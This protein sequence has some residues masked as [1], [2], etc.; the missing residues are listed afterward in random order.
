MKVKLLIL[1]AVLCLFAVTAFAALPADLTI[2]EPGA[3]EGSG[4]SGVVTL[5]DGVQTVGDRG[6]AA[7]EV[8]ALIVPAGCTSVAGTVLADGQAAYVL[9][10]G[11]AT[12]I[13]GTLTDVPFLFAPADSVMADAAGFH[14]LDT[15]MLQDNVY[16]DLSGG[17]AQPLCVANDQTDAVTIP[18]LVDGKPVASLD[19]MAFSGCDGL[20]LR[21]PAY[22][23]VPE[24]VT[25]ERYET[26]TVTSPVT[27][28]TVQAGEYASW[29]VTAAGVYGDAS[30]T[31]LFDNN[32]TTS[33]TVTAE[34][35]VTYAP[36]AGGTLTVT[37]TVQDALGDHASAA[38]EAVEVAAAVP[39]YRALL[40]GNVYSGALNELKGTDTDVRAMR[41]MLS[42]M[43][44]SA[45][46][47]NTQI[48][49]NASAILSA[50]SSNFASAGP[51]D[52][53]LFYFAGHGTS[54]GQLVGTGSTYINPAT[55]RA[56]LDKIPGQKI[57]ILDCCYSGAFISRSGEEAS[58]S[59]F[60][61][62]IISAF[63]WMSR[64]DTD[65]DAGGYHVLTACK[66]E[67]ESLSLTADSN[68]YWG[69]FTYGLCYSSG[70]DSWMQK[71]V[72]TL[73]ADSDGNGAI[74]LGEAY[75]GTLERLDYLA[76]MIELSQ[77]TQYTGDSSFVLWYK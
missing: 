43:T 48:D 55:L 14:A 30:Y 66:K 18:K 36:T 40:V 59:A 21:V 4:L 3:L 68:H 53:S 31:W 54:S 77:S 72:S 15:L 67:E 10:N 19:S 49:L 57:V 7:T 22:I 17:N 27:D 65:L 70:Y 42:A 8:H 44:G 35:T 5:P 64:G 41:T 9:L 39:V 51:A 25:A 58:P 71:S 16:Y 33:S 26:L 11:A 2:L 75:S 46:S 34:P 69:A 50:I 74:T 32:G 23:A 28:M 45:Y 56:A 12:T 29:S 76:T 24:A 60:N 37:V 38:S 20:T 62:A 63:S 61:S 52:V 1:T 6:F 13:T 73:S 47:V